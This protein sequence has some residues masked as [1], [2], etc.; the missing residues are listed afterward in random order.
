MIAG[1]TNSF[2][3]CLNLQASCLQRDIC[4]CKL[5]M[6]TCLPIQQQT[7]SHEKPATHSKFYMLSIGCLQQLVF[8]L[9]QGKS[10][11]FY[12]KHVMEE[13]TYSFCRNF[14]L[15]TA[16]DILP[17][18]DSFQANFVEACV[19]SSSVNLYQVWYC[20]TASYQCIS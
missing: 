5:R 7:A 3:T 9:Q 1:I 14:I 17:N 18:K 6:C 19:V 13:A 2:Q 10:A 8:Y 12:Q 11:Y 16:L 15:S 4:G 20:M